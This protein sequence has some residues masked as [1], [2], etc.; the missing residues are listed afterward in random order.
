MRGWAACNP[1]DDEYFIILDRLYDTLEQR[2]EK[3]KDVKKKAKG[4]FGFGAN[5]DALDDLMMD[6][7][8]VA[9]DLS[10]AFRYLHENK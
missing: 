1:L 4:K 3:W 6:R 7:L 10:C 5:K 8:L 2:M 9:Y